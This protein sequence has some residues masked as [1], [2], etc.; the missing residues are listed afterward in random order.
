MVVLHE[1]GVFARLGASEA[2][3][4]WIMIPIFVL[5]SIAGAG[6]QIGFPNYVMEMAPV[7]RRP[8]YL[9]LTTSIDGML[10]LVVPALGGLLIDATDYWVSF[11]A[12]AVLCG[13]SVVLALRLREPRAFAR[14][15]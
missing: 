4:I 13:M 8:V 5:L 12:A 6:M 9:G 15:K 3:L 11:A 2:L 1:T 7:R 10:T 14:G